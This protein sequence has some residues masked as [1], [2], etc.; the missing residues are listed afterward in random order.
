MNRKFRFVMMLVAI[1]AIGM[2]VRSTP[3]QAQNQGGT[4]MCIN[5]PGDC[6]RWA[7]G[8][9]GHQSGYY[10]VCCYDHW[11]DAMCPNEQGPLQGT[12]MSL[13]HTE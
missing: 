12:C 7:L 9:C 6:V 4:S 2:A 11:C 3:V 10:T 13:L 5:D 8:Q 1:L